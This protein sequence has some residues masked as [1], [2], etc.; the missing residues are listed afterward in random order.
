MPDSYTDNTNKDSRGVPRNIWRRR[1]YLAA[2]AGAALL[3][4][5]STDNPSDTEAPG[6]S[7]DTGD[8]SSRDI[9]KDV[10]IMSRLGSTS[11]PSDLNFNPFSQSGPGH[12]LHIACDL[13][14]A[15]VDPNTG[16]VTLRGL[17]DWQWD[18][19]AGALTKTLRD[20]LVRWNGDQVTAD[21]LYAYD[22]LT[23]LTAPDASPYESIEKTGD[24]SVQYV[25]KNPP[26]EQ[27]AR[28]VHVP[29]RLS[30]HNADQWQSWVEKFADVSTKDERESLNKELTQH[31]V[32]LQEYI[33]NGWGNG[34][35]VPSDWDET[36]MVYEQVGHGEHRY[37]DAVDIENLRMYLTGYESAKA[38]QLFIN[39]SV[40]FHT[41]VMP[42]KYKGSVPDYVQNLAKWEVMFSYQM[43]INQRNHSD[44]Q[45]RNVR[46]A[47][48]CVIN[49]KNVVTNFGDTRGDP[50]ETHSGMDPGSNQQYWGDELSNFIDYSPQKTDQQRAD[51]FLGKS[52]YSREGGTIYRPNG[53]EMQPIRMVT[54]GDFLFQTP[55][56][57][58]SL[59][60]QN[61]GFPVKYNA[62]PRSQ[63]L[64]TITDNMGD[65]DLSMESH[66]AAA[67]NHASSF[68]RNWYWG[69]R[70]SKEENNEQVRQW[71]EEGEERSPYTGKQL[72]PEIPST[73]GKE[74]L[75]G[76]TK[77]VNV[78]ETY[79]KVRSSND[80]A[81]V[82]Q[83]IR[84]LSQMWNFDVPNIDV[85][86][87]TAGAAG[88]TRDYEWPAAEEFPG[89]TPNPPYR[90]IADGTVTYSDY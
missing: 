47:M 82:K 88:N 81:E 38:D 48:A 51:Y 58:A 2:T 5:C 20:D 54:G 69:Y 72:T 7:T 55:S 6:G 57:T 40:D 44:L 66:Y 16:E 25:L 8:G 21:D 90:M 52:G 10:R 79:N 68:W 46:R 56:K 31:E 9:P 80:D 63:K 78:L 33:D 84:D 4:G 43:L 29:G 62:V 71:V 50:I 28:N 1:E 70:M 36:Q 76:S 34:V 64:T 11:L 22:E 32:P 61:Y 67:D 89:L 73:V 23:R 14:A 83:G 45:D 49:T 35:F 65:W 17:D 53:E 26:N 75:S 41:S 59:Q 13:Q 27:I 24:M 12:L 18:G 39:G 15:N 42:P 77:E 37:S 86:Y 30:W 85:L 87:L 19:D 3:A 74:D 60:L